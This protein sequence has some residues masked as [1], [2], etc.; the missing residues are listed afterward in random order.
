M[1]RIVLIKG[2]RSAEREVSLVSGRECAAGLREA[3]YKVEELDLPVVIR[4]GASQA[5]RPPGRSDAG[6][7][8]TPVSS[9]R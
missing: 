3:G 7:G 2:G 8:S 1:K 4:H 9:R 6:A 5:H